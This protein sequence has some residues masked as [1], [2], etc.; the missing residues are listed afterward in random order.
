MGCVCQ[1]DMCP[2]FNCDALTDPLRGMFCYF[3]GLCITQCAMY[4]SVYL[5]WGSCSNR[6]YIGLW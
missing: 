4:E 6:D 2:L 1:I 3:I 5:R